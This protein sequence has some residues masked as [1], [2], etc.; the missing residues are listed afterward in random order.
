MSVHLLIGFPFYAKCIKSLS[1][2][3][4]N[5][6]RYKF[7]R[8]VDIMEALTSIFLETIIS[9]CIS[10]VMY[11]WNSVQS[12]RDGL[13]SDHEEASETDPSSASGPSSASV[14]PLPYFSYEMLHCSKF[15]TM[16]DIPNKEDKTPIPN[17]R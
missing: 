17:N 15:H 13:G 8:K 1:Y 11:S 3:K 5:I 14:K 6:M 4:C 12:L 7:K 2:L 9:N 16:R 10:P